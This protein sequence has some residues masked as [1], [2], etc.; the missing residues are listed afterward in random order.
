M[1]VDFLEIAKIELDDAIN[2]YNDL[3]E[4]LGY[5]FF[6]EVENSLKSI[7]SF[8][9]A[10]KLVGN[11]TRR[12]VINRFSYFLL[13]YISEEKIYITCVAHQHRDPE[14]YKNRLE[15]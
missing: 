9:L 7:L 1:N 15:L 11:N 3:N 13:Y 6:K 12:C 4:N 2:W 10:W 5:E 14:Y 8:P